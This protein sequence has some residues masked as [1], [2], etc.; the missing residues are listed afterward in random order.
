MSLDFRLFRNIT[1]TSV[2]QSQNTIDNQQ[3]IITDHVLSTET[4]ILVLD[5]FLNIVNINTAVN[6]ENIFYRDI[7]F[8]VSIYKICIKYLYLFCANIYSCDFSN[9]LSP[10][11]T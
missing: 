6:Q 10:T 4:A 5:K 2:T 8:Y 7:S 3:L 9:N 1:C 11:L